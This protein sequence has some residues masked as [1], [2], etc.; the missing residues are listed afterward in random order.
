MYSQATPKTPILIGSECRG[1]LDEAAAE[2]VRCPSGG[3]AFHAGAAVL[4]AV[5]WET[6]GLAMPNPGCC[7]LRRVVS[8]CLALE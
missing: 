5:V 4:V 7:D 2:K 8:V 6:T 3:E 1:P